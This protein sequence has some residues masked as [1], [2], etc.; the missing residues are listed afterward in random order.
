MNTI[1][2][3]LNLTS[4]GIQYKMRWMSFEVAKKGNYRIIPSSIWFLW[5]LQS[6][7]NMRWIKIFLKRVF[8]SILYADK[9][10]YFLKDTSS[11]FSANSNEILFFKTCPIFSFCFFTLACTCVQWC[12]DAWITSGRN[13]KSAQTPL[14]PPPDC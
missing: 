10:Q 13:R 5:L 4:K 2:N 6:I 3:R 12:S 14:I 7:N 1:V 9:L 11:F 8:Y